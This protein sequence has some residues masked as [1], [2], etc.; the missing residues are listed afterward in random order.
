MPV[1][2]LSLSASSSSARTA[3]ARTAIVLAL[4]ALVTLA[5]HEVVLT[6]PWVDD[7]FIF[8]RYATNWG[9]GLGLVF[10]RGEYVEGFSSFLWTAML[11]L[12]SAVGLSPANTAPA[13]GLLLAAGC[14]VLVTAI[15][16]TLLGFSAWLAALAAVALALSPAFATYATS[17]MDVM[18]FAFVLLAAVA[19]CARMV[20]LSREGPVDGRSTALAV[21]LLVAL[22][23]VRA[24][25]PI[26]AV[27]IGVAAA[28]LSSPGDGRRRST[29]ALV[30]PA[31]AVLA[32]GVVLVVRRLVYGVWAPA[33]VLAKGYTNHLAAHALHDPNARVALRDALRSGVDYA[34]PLVFVVLAVIVTA[35]VVRRRR[36]TRLPALPLLGALAIAVAL[37]TT[38]WSSG[39]WM[40]FR[41]LLVPVLP[42]LVLLTAWAAATIHDGV[43]RVTRPG[44]ASAWLRS[45]AAGVGCALAIVAAGVSPGATAPRYEA[46]QLE[47]VGRL[48]AA[49][50][51]PTHLLTNLDGV[52][53]YYAGSRTYV[54]DM[55]GLT[56]IHNARYGLI[57]SSRFGR[58]DPRYDFSRPFD[59]FV[60]NSSWDFAL[61][62]TLLPSGP[63]RWLLFSSPRWE[64]I[65]L[66]VV[67]RAGGPL[68][69][70]LQR[71]CG[72]RPTALTVSARRA[73]LAELLARGA[74]PP[75][76]VEA[77]RQ[78][79]AFP[80]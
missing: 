72:C 67:A 44:S 62:A 19:A 49:A 28:M 46:Q 2:R 36:D 74:V 21:V 57:F 51:G 80:A 41:R 52:L 73:L 11:A 22:V 4:P 37:A 39:D 34:G 13:L 1:E 26:Y 9:H 68:P 23:L 66:Y 33:T 43:R 7:S 38:L 70:G 59:L 78:R 65:P 3:P 25:G 64:A 31:A 40:P 10:N 71:L 61:M 47:A 27:L 77:A 17:G 15:G 50:P 56:D 75:G 8:Y 55:L 79:R 12:P 29:R 42:L 5:I 24:E 60:S 45:L 14:I 53:P 16:P 76:L 6:R 20:E 63:Q 30:L 48:L 32:V 18:L 58:T 35:I 54:W 69:A